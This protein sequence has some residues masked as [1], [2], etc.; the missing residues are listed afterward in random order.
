M[1]KITKE[2]FANI[3]NP[4][5]YTGGEYNEA[6]KYKD[7]VKTRVALCYP[8]LYDIGMNNYAMLY[9]Y[10]AINSQKE[11]YAERVFMPAFDFEC[12]LKK[13]REE[14]YTL[15]TKSK[16]NSFD[17][18]VFILSNEVEYINVIT[19][20]KLTNIKNRTAE[21]PILIGFFEGFQCNH[22][23]LDD[24]FDIFVYN[25][26]KIVYKDILFR[27]NVY[28]KQKLS[29]DDFLESINSIDNVIVPKINS[30][31]VLNKK[32]AIIME[33][34]MSSVPVSSMSNI[35][36][37][38]IIKYNPDVVKMYQ[39]TVNLIKN[40]G[41]KDIKVICIED[42]NYNNLYNYI[43]A[44]KQDFIFLNLSIDK[45]PYNLETF[46]IYE[47]TGMINL[48]VVFEII[49]ANSKKSTIKNLESNIELAIKRGAKKIY[50]NVFI[51]YD[52]E[53]YHDLEKI[54]K[55]INNI[56][57]K[58]TLPFDVNFKVNFLFDINGDINS[59]G[60][61]EKFLEEKI[62]NVNY[63]FESLNIVRLKNLLKYGKKDSINLLEIASNNLIRVY[64]NIYDIDEKRIQKTFK[65]LNMDYDC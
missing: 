43:E 20:L 65:D 17:F 3:D 29:I 55:C 47:Y 54:A 19:M 1:L 49:A 42:A 5:R 59:F 60:L 45:L 33:K 39:E 6:K 50:L 9:L 11:I 34:A 64:K 10:N 62:F 51:G 48:K 24:I 61:R 14:L 32:C 15:E 7:N 23:P 36:Q 13:N 30:E 56:K 63:K 26:L 57:E 52:N 53:T 41:I 16:L 22:K 46:K 58:I 18:I 2:N 12:F 27:Y 38:L 44:L 25:N 8:N 40:T 28:N 21:K 4:L 37:K 35:N 31:K